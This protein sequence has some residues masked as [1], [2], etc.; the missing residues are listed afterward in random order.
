MQHLLHWSEE[1]QNFFGKFYIQFSDILEVLILAFLIYHI[2]VWVQKTRAWVLFKGLI[3]IAIFLLVALALD[4]DTILWIAQNILG[5][6]ITAVVIIL[7]PE[8]RKALE[9]LGKNGFLERFRL[10]DKR[11]EEG[12]FS[13]KTLQGILNASVAMGKAKTGALIV[14]ERNQDLADYASTGITIDAIV[15][16]QLLINIFEHNTPLH[17][18][19][20]VI[21]GDRLVAA[22]CYLPLSD[23]RA[24]SKELGTRHR[25]A[26]GASENTDA[27]IVI[28]SEETG[29]ISVAREGN[30]Y[31]NL[32]ADGLQEHLVRFQEKRTEQVQAKSRII[33]R[34]KGTK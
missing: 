4:M 23:N 26:L 18:G 33:K 7:Q 19:A 8:L 9:E 28:V 16:S 14:L 32:G 27:L 11:V 31:R 20:V 3:V 34:L 13:D 6:A 25:A 21:K 22:T 29:A 10:I 2:L 12:R 1:I 17:D 24:V 15:T 5:V 30:L